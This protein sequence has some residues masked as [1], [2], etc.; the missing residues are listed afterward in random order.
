MV[1]YVEGLFAEIIYI[2][3]N[4][5]VSSDYIICTSNDEKIMPMAEAPISDTDSSSYSSGDE[6]WLS[7]SKVSTSKSELQMPPSLKVQS[8]QSQQL[9]MLPSQNL[10]RQ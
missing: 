4:E 10:Q 5:E 6:D 2:S 1:C 3:S 9:K 7:K 8:L